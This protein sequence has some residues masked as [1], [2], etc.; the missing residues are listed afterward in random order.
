MKKIT[1]IR[2]G[3]V[4]SVAAKPGSLVTISQVN[5]NGDCRIRVSSTK[6]KA[7]NLEKL[8]LIDISDTVLEKIGYSKS[9]ELY[10]RYYGTCKV[11][12][13]RKS[14]VAGKNWHILVQDQSENEIC[15][16]CIEYLNDIQ[17]ELADCEINIGSLII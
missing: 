17:N 7:I 13:S 2:V 11:I 8:S 12:V 9:Q 14:V 10:I 15:S 5:A 3:N 1:S 16:K 6:E 4:L